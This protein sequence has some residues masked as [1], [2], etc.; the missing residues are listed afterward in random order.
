MI[1]KYLQLF[2]SVI[3]IPY[4]PG[5]KRYGKRERRLYFDGAKVSRQNKAFTSQINSAFTGLY[6]RE[7]ERNENFSGGYKNIL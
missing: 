5:D 2:D 4:T 7:I 1:T 3:L 6:L